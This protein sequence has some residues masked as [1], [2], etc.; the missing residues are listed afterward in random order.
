MLDLQVLTNGLS[1][2][3]LVVTMTEDDVEIVFKSLSG[4]IYNILIASKCMHRIN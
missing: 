4:Q 1:L 3:D 2:F